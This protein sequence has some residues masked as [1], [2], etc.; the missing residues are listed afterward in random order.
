MAVA[1][2]PLAL[3]FYGFRFFAHPHPDAW[4]VIGFLEA[5]Y[6]LVAF[7]ILAGSRLARW[8]CVTW[9]AVV[10]VQGMIRFGQFSG[11]LSQQ[12]F[13]VAYWTIQVVA[14]APLFSPSAMLH[15]KRKGPNQLPEPT[16]LLGH[17]RSETL[18]R[19]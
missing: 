5:A 4:L 3:G 19:K 16:A 6:S 17:G 15:F 2:C 11:D 18:G 7:A 1:F 13:L 14:I 8:F 10:I 9:M 12:V